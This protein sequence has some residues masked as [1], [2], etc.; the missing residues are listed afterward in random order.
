M[1]AMTAAHVVAMKKP[2]PST[3][4]I[5]VRASHAGTSMRHVA[6]GRRA[7]VELPPEAVCA[8]GR[9]GRAGRPRR[10]P[11]RGTGQP[12]EHRHQLARAAAPAWPATSAGSDRRCAAA[13]P[14]AR[15]VPA[16][17]SRATGRG[18]ARRSA[19]GGPTAS[20]RGSRRTRRCRCGRRRCWPM[21]C[22]GAMYAGVPIIAPARVSLVWRVC[23]GPSSQAMPKSTI[24]AL[25]PA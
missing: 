12:V 4:P 23:P 21:S 25:R 2:R 16:S 8:A 17:R 24:L 13:A 22:S 10:R 20:R 14:R 9:R 15:R 7:L 5:V 1:L 18:V 6:H 11:V 3:P 19:D